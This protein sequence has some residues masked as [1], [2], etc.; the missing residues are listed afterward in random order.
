MWQRDFRRGACLPA[1]WLCYTGDSRKPNQ[2]YPLTG[3]APSRASGIF[4]C[5]GGMVMVLGS[6]L[7]CLFLLPFGIVGL[8]ISVMMILTGIKQFEDAQSGT[9]PY[10][11]NAVTVPTKDLICKCPHCRKTSTKKDGFLETID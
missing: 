2:A 11:G 4:L 6:L 8:V 3:K 10:C 9:C 1:L 5:A 7:F